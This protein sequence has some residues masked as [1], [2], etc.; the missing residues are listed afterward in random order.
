MATIHQ[1]E[2]NRLNAQKSTGPR[3][4]RGKAVSR[5]NALKTGID[6]QS[7]VIPGEDPAA[8]ETLTIDH[9][10]RFQPAAP[11][12]FFLVDAMVAAAWQLRRLRHAEAQIWEYA[13]HECR[14]KE[15]LVSSGRAFIRRQ[16]Q[17]T[18]LHRRI[19]AA[20]RSYYRAL[21]QLL[22][23]QSGLLPPADAKARSP[24]APSAPEF[25]P[26]TPL[27]A[28][29]QPPPNQS[30]TSGIGFVPANRVAAIGPSLFGSHTA[31]APNLAF[32]DCVACW[33]GPSA[34][35]VS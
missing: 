24:Q 33:D 34:R 32:G 1:I 8:L 7:H 12:H 9:Y 13:M 3:T 20:E 30:S 22:Q 17:F 29:L 31:P 2:A 16:E 21:K 10:A 19:D 35:E 11:E 18:R 26:S 15:D 25:P 5:L 27:P 23:L 6:A 14:P 4:P 28:E